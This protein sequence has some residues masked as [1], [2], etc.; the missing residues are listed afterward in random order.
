MPFQVSRLSPQI[1]ADQQD[2]VVNVFGKG[3]RT[4]GQGLQCKT[5][6]LTTTEATVRAEP[7][8]L[9]RAKTRRRFWVRP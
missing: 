8:Q 1:W 3:F 7:A 2:A 6:H 9:L 4:A 5:S